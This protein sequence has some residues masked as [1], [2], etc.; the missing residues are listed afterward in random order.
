[1]SYWVKFC[2][3]AAALFVMIGCGEQGTTESNKTVPITKAPVEPV[4]IQLELYPKKAPKTVERIVKFIEDGYYEKQR[5]HRVESWVIQWGSPAS[6]S[7]NL[8]DPS[9]GSGGSGM[10]ILPFEPNDLKMEPGTLA[11]ASTGAKVGG[12][13]QLYI[14]TSALEQGQAQFM[15]GNYAV[16]GKVSSGMEAVDSV[17][18]GDYVSM[19]VTEKTPDVVKVELTVTPFS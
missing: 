3:A 2:V 12:D 6:K 7:A 11:M 14:L 4:V 10:P 18:V 15:Q 17:K 9:V 1:M 5:F 16:F 19:K 8:Q 13:S